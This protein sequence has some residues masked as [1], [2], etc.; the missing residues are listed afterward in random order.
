MSKIPD[1]GPRQRGAFWGAGAPICV[2]VRGGELGVTNGC[3]WVEKTAEN[4]WFFGASLFLMQYWAATGAGHGHRRERHVSRKFWGVG[5]RKFVS[6]S[7]SYMELD[8]KSFTIIITYIQKDFFL[9]Y[10]KYYIYQMQR[11]IANDHF[12]FSWHSKS[13]SVSKIAQQYKM[14]GF[15]LFK[16]G[17]S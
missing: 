1:W 9:I 8:L 4:S 7:S 5:R 11:T 6:E 3:W 10:V 13:Y 2:C 14:Y 16:D 12:V 15:G 17:R